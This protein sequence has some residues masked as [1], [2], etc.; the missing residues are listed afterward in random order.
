MSRLGVLTLLACALVACGSGGETDPSLEPEPGTVVRSD[1]TASP[2]AAVAQSRGVRLVRI[3]SF[4]S[5]VH[6]TSPPTDRRRLFVV[7]QGGVVR[8]VRGGRVLAQPFLD[9][10][11]R[12]TSGGEQGL[13]SIAFPPD[14]A[15]TRRFY[16]YFNNG[17]C[18]SGTGG[19]DIEVAEF[20]RTLKSATRARARSHRRVLTIRHRD[21][22]NHNGGTAMFGPDGKLWLATGDGGGA[23][24][25]FDNARKR[26]SLLGKLLRIDPR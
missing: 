10:R 3:G 11:S 19:C 1:A 21:A 26:T 20:R 5:P 12:V 18:D 24:D 9:I 13:L 17:N 4:S 15:Q 16:A 2:E 8:V 6:V 14:Y 25:E 22:A 23:G 7:Q